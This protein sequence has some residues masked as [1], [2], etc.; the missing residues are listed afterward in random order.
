M[1]KPWLQEIINKDNQNIDYDEIIWRISTSPMDDLQ[2]LVLNSWCE[3]E[4]IPV[5]LK[6]VTA[7][8]VYL[9]K[10]SSEECKKLAKVFLS[11]HCTPDE[12]RD[13]LDIGRNE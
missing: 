13:A 6:C 7:R 11:A 2:E 8:I 5:S 1:M 10:G 12:E 4:H 9:A 3:Y